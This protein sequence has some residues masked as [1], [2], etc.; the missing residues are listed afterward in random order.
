MTSKTV[1]KRLWDFGLIH[2]A[3]LMS[4]IA[5]GTGGRTGYEEITGKTPDIS[6]WMDFDLYDAIWYHDPPDTM[7]EMTSEVQKLGRWLG[8]ASSIGSALTYW[9]LTRAC[10]IIARSTIQHLTA[11]ERQDKTMNDRINDFNSV[12]TTRL[13]IEGF[14]IA[15]NLFY[16][17]NILQDADEIGDEV[18]HGDGTHTPT[19]EEYRLD[20]TDSKKKVSTS[21]PMINF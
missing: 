2:Q 19:D 7:A 11:T 16:G 3:E 9:V 14:G 20:K 18:A 6:E 13:Q 17:E 1:P 15:E 8:V 12:V 10:K 5:R 4:R 21:K